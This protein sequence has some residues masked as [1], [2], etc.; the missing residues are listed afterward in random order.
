[1]SGEKKITLPVPSPDIG[2]TE[3]VDKLMCDLLERFIV[4]QKLIEQPDQVQAR[5]NVLSDLEQRI[6][7]WIYETYRN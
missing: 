7:A 2:Y 6:S 3:E 4:Q 1:M 5:R